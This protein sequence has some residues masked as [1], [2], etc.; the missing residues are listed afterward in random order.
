MPNSILLTPSGAQVVQTIAYG[1]TNHPCGA[2]RLAAV[3]VENLG[4]NRSVEVLPVATLI[5]APVP[6][7]LNNVAVQRPASLDD[8]LD[9]AQVVGDLDGTIGGVA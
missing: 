2:G 6:T 1:H 4:G 5:V 7:L 9:L 3:V 8:L